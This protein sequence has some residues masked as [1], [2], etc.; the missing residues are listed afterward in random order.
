MTATDSQQTLKQA[1]KNSIFID[2]LHGIVRTT[3]IKTAGRN[4][5]GGNEPLVEKNQGKNNFFEHFMS[6][7]FEPPR[8]PINS[9]YT[10]TKSI[11]DAPLLAMTEMSLDEPRSR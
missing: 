8:I 1:S 3:G 9:L 10:V 7:F 4:F 2:C 6:M 5:Q 11:S